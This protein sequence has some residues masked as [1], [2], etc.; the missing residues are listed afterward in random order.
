MSDLLWDTDAQEHAQSA[1]AEVRDDHSTNDW[2]FL[3]YKGSKGRDAQTIVFGATGSGGLAELRSHFQDDKCLFCLLRVTDK[4]DESV[5]VKFVFIHWLGNSLP[6]FQR[7]KVTL[8]IAPMKEFIGQS[9]VQLQCS[10]H[11][12]ITDEIVME[13]VM[14]FSGSGSR[15]L[16]EQGESTLKSQARKSFVGEIKTTGS[17]KTEED[18]LFGPEI[19]Q[20]IAEVRNDE[21]S[22]LWVLVGYQNPTSN[23][24]ELISTGDGNVEDLKQFLRDDIVAYG[25]IRKTERID[26]SVTVKF[27]YIRWVGMNIPR[28]QRAKIGIHRGQANQA[29][30]PY[31]VDIDC[32]RHDELSDDIVE[33]TIARA[34]GQKIHILEN[35]S[36]DRQTLYRGAVSSG[37]NTSSTPP[38]QNTP[39]TTSSTTNTVNQPIRRSSIKMETRTVGASS[40]IPVNLKDEDAIREFIQSVRR[41]D[42]PTDWCLITYDAPKSNTLITLQRGSG[43]IEEMASHLADNI[44]AYGLLR[45]YDQIDL[46]ATVKFCFVD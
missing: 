39:L 25:L 22:K 31:H 45:K 15:V 23:Q 29:F 14:D 1:I 20:A 12:E 24:M 35:V 30:H 38:P 36:A 18:L 6:F 21:H 16:N 9:H 7:G 34:S 37:T 17:K 33:T 3:T 2:V 41:D 13:K 44:I 43:G 10:T 11:D 26:N 32:E 4:I 46:S 28:M 42:D 19:H 8:H 40:D 27:C 5:T